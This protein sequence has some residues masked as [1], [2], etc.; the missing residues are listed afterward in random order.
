[1]VRTGPRKRSSE[2]RLVSALSMAGVE[3]AAQGGRETGPTIWVDARTAAAQQPQQKVI[4]QILPVWTP[5]S[6]GHP[7]LQDSSASPLLPG[8]TAQLM[9]WSS[10]IARWE[11]MTYL[12]SR[13]GQPGH[14]PLP[15]LIQ[16]RSAPSSVPL[17]SRLSEWPLEKDSEMVEPPGRI[18][19]NP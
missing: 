6:T 2:A 12:D 9:T 4:Q 19:L 11:R 1:M 5:L 17:P 8:Y 7:G 16:N 15:G 3:G 13:S 10:L 18:N 14:G